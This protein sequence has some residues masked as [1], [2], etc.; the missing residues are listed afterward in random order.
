SPVTPPP[1]DPFKLLPLSSET[2]FNIDTSP[3]T[4]DNRVEKSRGAGQKKRKATV[5]QHSLQRQITEQVIEEEK[6]EAAIETYQ[7]CIQLLR[8]HGLTFGDFVMYY[9]DPRNGQG[10]V[11]WH[12]F[13][14]VPG[15]VTQILEWWA[16]AKS[17]T[18]R[19]EVREWAIS[20]VEEEV[21][22]QARCITREGK[23]RGSDIT[24]ESVSAFS[25]SGL[26]EYFT[27]P[28]IGDILVRVFEAVAKSASARKCS[29][30]RQ[31]R[32][33]TIVTSAI[34]SCLSEYNHRNSNV[35]RMM[36]LYFYGSGTHRQT[37]SVLSRLGICESY[38][39]IVRQ[40]RL[41]ISKSIK[42]DP[43]PTPISN[44]H[45]RLRL[46]T[47]RKLSIHRRGMAAAI[48]TLGLYA[49][50]YDNI[51]FLSR[52]AEQ[53]TAKH[54]FQENGTCITIFV[55]W[56]T[57]FNELLTKKLRE[58]FNHARPLKKEDIIHN[59][60]EA[61]LF[62]EMMIHTILR[63]I[64]TTSGKERLQNYIKEQKTRQPHSDTIIKPHKTEIYPLACVNIDES[65]IKG[66]AEVDEAVIDILGLRKS[67]DKFWERVRV[68]SGDQLSLARLRALENIRAGH[69]AGYEGFAWGVWMPGLFHGKMA[70]M[71]GFLTIH[72]GKSPSA[73]NPAS[74]AFHNACLNR[75]PI[76]P[77]SLPNFRT[78]R[79]LVFTSLYARV[80]HCL[81]LVSGKKSLEEYADTLNS[82]EQLYG[83]AKAIYRMYADAGMVD[84][85]RWEREF[86]GEGK[87][88]M[89]YENAI[90][91]LRD[92]LI[93][94]EFTDAVKA[95]DSGRILLVLKI[96]ALSFR[97]NGRT[98]YAYEML[99]LIHSVTSVWP[100][101]IRNIVL[102]NWLVNTTGKPDS[103]LEVDLMQEHLN[104]WIKVV[105]KA[106]GSNSSWEWL[107]MITP[108]IGIL[109]EI[110]RKMNGML[111]ADIGAK[112]TVADLGDDIY[113]LMK[114]LDE[115]DVYRLKRGR[116]L[117]SDEWAT[118]I[119]STGLQ[120][121]TDTTNN[122]LNDYNTAFRKLQQRR[123]M[124]PVND[125]EEVIVDSPA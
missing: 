84:D 92:A 56:A 25:Y 76:T 95:G 57:K 54:D 53:T 50:V 87:G 74:L 86:E 24:E 49:E 47:L 111:G 61:K 88:D 71:H 90:L 68:I 20:F 118:D 85:L 75:L 35:K 16:K 103:F 72:L 96:W 33:K 97:G 83:D 73:K 52:I 46:G 108:C 119:I 23:L 9:L 89:V 26:Y 100:K 69:E 114:S 2:D 121:L 51:N 37:I 36:G 77:T 124:R 32:Q 19:A 17:H 55:L 115:Y 27:T 120:A 62:Q 22:K 48:A 21:Q 78:C 63:I 110:A 4:K 65:T 60:Q 123:H 109:R 81:L 5:S 64:I 80:L 122:P 29:E 3:W 79:D 58:A 18:L 42:A 30:A 67:V 15:R 41:R 112:H 98:K 39:N 8:T 38:T 125:E 59:K 113:T 45:T 82:W 117:D 11:R 66:N 1:K 13:L 70:D 6:K 105:Y 94:R 12:D 40:D 28:G 44:L 104:Y 91:F 14:A 106:H 7:K 99:H 43:D 116:M 107:D 10:A 34:V 102:N 101:E 31:E 93:S